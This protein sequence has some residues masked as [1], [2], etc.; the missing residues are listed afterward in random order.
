ML[1]VD[2]DGTCHVLW[3]ARAGQTLLVELPDGARRPLTT[4]D[5]ATV[6]VVAVPPAQ[7][8]TGRLFDTAGGPPL[9]VLP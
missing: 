5:V 9:L 1:A 6:A 2:P 8:G 3:V 7:R 4:V